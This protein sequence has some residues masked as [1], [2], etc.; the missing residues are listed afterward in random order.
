MEIPYSRQSIDDDDVAA[1]VRVLRS[2][3]LTQGPAIEEFEAR[4]ITATGARFAVVFSSGSAALH[5]ACAAA[6]LGPGDRVATS[7]LSFVASANC[8]VHVGA[9]PV[10]LDLD[11][12]TWNLDPERVGDDIDALVAVHF[13]GLPVD[14]GS[15]PVRPRVVIEDAAHALGART[16]AGPVGNCAHSDLCCFSFHPVKAVTSGE[17]GAVT[18]NDP[19][20]AGRLRSFRSH[21]LV[22]QPAVAGWYYDVTEAGWNYRLTDLQAALGASQLGKLEAFVAARNELAERYRRRLLGAPLELPPAAPPGWRHAY[23][24]FAVGVA[25]RR[26]VYDGLRAAGIGAQVH[27]T[28]IHQLSFYRDAAGGP[29]PVADAV[30]SGLLSIPLFPTLGTERQDRVVDALVAVL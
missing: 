28:P 12:A 9:E 25:D 11:P 29:W 18:T 16:P 6:G 7:T 30:A 20:L 8:I 2:D 10:L 4:L 14:L 3:R 22:H 26:R 24:L 27:Y 15:L 5:A 23:H 17:G 13:A 21:G 1:V 19:V